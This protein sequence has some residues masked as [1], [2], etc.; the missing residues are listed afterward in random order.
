MD[1]CVALLSTRTQSSFAVAKCTTELLLCI[2]V[3]QQVCTSTHCMKACCQPDLPLPCF[4]GAVRAMLSASGYVLPKKLPDDIV[5]LPQREV[6]MRGTAEYQRQG[7]WNPEPAMPRTPGAGGREAIS[8]KLFIAFSPSFLYLFPL[9]LLCLLSNPT[10]P[11]S[12]GVK[13][14]E[15]QEAT[16]E[17]AAAQPVGSESAQP[18]QRAHGLSGRHSPPGKGTPFWGS[19][20]HD[21][22]RRPLA[23]LRLRLEASK[24]A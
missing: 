9:A 17:N 1:I 7:G 2:C 23:T 19:S 14:C 18:L 16:E 22:L 21:N 15:K 4:R 5:W 12:K 3:A 20:S 8:N 13:G 6:N 10:A 24:R 11:P